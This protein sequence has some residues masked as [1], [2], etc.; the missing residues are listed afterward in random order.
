[1]YSGIK[2]DAE[3]EVGL[4]FDPSLTDTTSLVLMSRTDLENFSEAKMLNLIVELLNAEFFIFKSFKLSFFFFFSFLTFFQHSHDLKIMFL[5]PMKI[6]VIAK[7][8]SQIGLRQVR[9]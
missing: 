8:S 2:F 4:H 7:E 5:S 6:E 9:F 3:S 1:M